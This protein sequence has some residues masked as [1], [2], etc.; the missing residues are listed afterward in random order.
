MATRAS[1][2]A[3][4]T[5]ILLAP[6]FAVLLAGCGSSSTTSTGPSPVKCQV[7]L[8][9]P[10]T[11][12]GAAGGAGTV[13]V[14]TTPECAW[15]AAADV[16]WITSLSPASG[17]G[18]G[19]I[20]FVVS[21]NPNP[22][23]R[24]GQVK[25]NDASVQVSQDGSP[26]L[27]ELNPTSQSVAATGGT[28]SVAVTTLA[29]CAWT[30]ASDSP[31][32]TV[33]SGG[34]GSASGSVG[35]SASPNS[36]AAR[37]GTLTI[38]GKTFT[39]AQAA[40]GNAQCSF[41]IQPTAQSMTLAGGGATIAVQAGPG[42]SWSAA[43]N[44]SWLVVVGNATGTGNGAVTISAQPNTGNS[45]VG[46]LTIAGQTFTVTQAGSCSTSISPLNQAV[47]F[48]GGIG[49][50]VA[51]TAGAGCPW[52]ATS[53]DP[54]LTITAGSNGSGNGTVVFSAAANAGG[55]R[56]GTLAIAGHLFTVTQG[57]LCS[58]SINPTSANVPSAGGPASPIT[59]TSLLGCAWTATTTDS[60]ITITAGASG[61]GDG[62]VTY[63]VAA[64]A[65]GARIGAIAVAGHIFTVNQ[66]APPAPPA[67]SCAASLSAA[68]QTLPLLGG[69]ATV[70]VT[71]A[72][73]CAWTATTTDNW[74]TITG[75]S[76]GTGNGTVSFAVGLNLLAT[77]RGTITIAGQ[78]FAVTQ[79]GLLGGDP[80]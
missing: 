64:N 80:Q 42:C 71:I 21:A 41:A 59:V 62:S 49:F 15:T 9:L 66:A 50:T 22:G 29:G 79:T 39:V 60:W 12:V 13:S 1:T 14:S 78:S 45:R 24:Q 8:T 53:G 63:T 27:F 35:F 70:D 47:G 37:I 40:P 34:S 17:Q 31:W 10:T 11:S 20:Q 44:A 6:V 68:S 52:T 57:A 16:G 23:K 74:I 75:G 32:L 72:A 58:T 36:G 76:S 56:T 46:T 43:S 65:G 3:L 38:G 33:T 61:S 25:T 67:P 19:Q 7:S 69:G 4:R 48:A 26:C 2:G 5:T 54:W 73:G 30:A 77:R 55:P 51:V 28:G 18:S